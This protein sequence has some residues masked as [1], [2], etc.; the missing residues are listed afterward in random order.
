[1]RDGAPHLA[2]QESSK[3]THSPRKS[4]ACRALAKLKHERFRQCSEQS[5]AP[6]NANCGLPLQEDASQAEDATSS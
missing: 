4:C 6:S 5:A 2:V 1:M 3:L